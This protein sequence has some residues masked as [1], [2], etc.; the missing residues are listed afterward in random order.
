MLTPRARIEAAEGK[1]VKARHPVLTAS[2]AAKKREA[3]AIAETREQR[4]RRSNERRRRNTHVGRG[5]D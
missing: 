2:S 4:E 3:R 1:G 5:H